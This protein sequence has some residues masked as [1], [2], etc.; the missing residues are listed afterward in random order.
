M[1][2]ASAVRS[3]RSGR[4]SDRLRLDVLDVLFGGRTLLMEE[5]S[6]PGERHTVTAIS[7][8]VAPDRAIRIVMPIQL[9]EN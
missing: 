4:R 5:Q 7:L 1:V 9:A 3:V 6:A 2:L 8:R